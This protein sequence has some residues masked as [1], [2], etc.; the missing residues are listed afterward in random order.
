[1][2]NSYYLLIVLQLIVQ[3]DSVGLVGLRPGEGDAVHGAA[4]LV[5]DGHSGRS[6]ERGKKKQTEKNIVLKDRSTDKS[7]RLES[8]RAASRHE[9]LHALRQEPPGTP[10]PSLSAAILTIHLGLSSG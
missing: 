5:H 7:Q 2:K 6:C 3:D 1:M 9:A 8:F 4:D 10:P